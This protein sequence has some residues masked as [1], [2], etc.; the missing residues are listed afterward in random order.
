MG[1]IPIVEIDINKLKAEKL[2]QRVR[3]IDSERKAHEGTLLRQTKHTI[4]IRRD[5]GV[6]AVFKL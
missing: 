4:K 1:Y 2:T 6:K 5:D 3:I